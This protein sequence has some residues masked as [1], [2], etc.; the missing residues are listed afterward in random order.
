LFA[1][2]AI[3]IVA[4]HVGFGPGIL[5]ALVVIPISRLL[6]LVNGS[7]LPAGAELLRL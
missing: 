6:F 3:M 1:I 2:T 4:W 5:A 7:P